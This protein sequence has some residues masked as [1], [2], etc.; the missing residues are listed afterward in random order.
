M[1]PS[2]TGGSV[3]AAALATASLA[4][5]VWRSARSAAAQPCNRDLVELVAE[6]LGPTCDCV[7]TGRWGLATGFLGGVLLVVAGL[8]VGD[9]RRPAPL[10][11]GPAT[12]TATAVVVAAQ[13]GQPS[14]LTGTKG[15]ISKARGGPLRHLAIDAHQF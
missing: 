10:A 9:R 8:L 13:P 4:A 6:A 12:A 7:A 5:A 1:G 14:K 11:P 3:F 15:G 2:S